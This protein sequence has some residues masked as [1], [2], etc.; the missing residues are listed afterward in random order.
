MMLRVKFSLPLIK[1]IIFKIKGHSFRGSEGYF[2]NQEAISTE[3]Y[4]LGVVQLISISLGVNDQDPQ[5]YAT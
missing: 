2:H 4:Y 5:L 3:E 1:A